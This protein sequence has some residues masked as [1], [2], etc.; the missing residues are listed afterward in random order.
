MLV[1]VLEKVPSSLRGELT[2]WLI[3]PRT[4]GYVPGPAIYHP[5]PSAVVEDGRRKLVQVER[6]LPRSWCRR[7]QQRWY[8][9]P[10]T[11]P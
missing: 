11:A 8:G 3:E 4:G 6:S 1:M 5:V 7:G 2:R 10:S 9:C